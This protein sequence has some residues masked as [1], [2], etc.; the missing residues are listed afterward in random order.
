MSENIFDLKDDYVQFKVFFDSEDELGL[1][2][3]MFCNINLKENIIEFNE[4]DEDYRENIIKSFL[5]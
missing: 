1:Y 2:S 4:K 5:Y 3:E